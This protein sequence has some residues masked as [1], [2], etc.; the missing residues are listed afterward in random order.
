MPSPEIG[1]CV[2]AP[3]NAILSLNNQ[4]NNQDLTICLDN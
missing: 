2:L 4:I 1:N 3:Y